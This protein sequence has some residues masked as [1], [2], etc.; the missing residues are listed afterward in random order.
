MTMKVPVARNAD[1]SPITGIVRSE[2]TTARDIIPTTPT[3][4]LNLSSGW[5]TGMITKSYPTVSTD[6]G[7]A[8]TRSCASIRRAASL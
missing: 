5:F 7:T 4:T 8:S 1:G 3:T 2:L 6:N